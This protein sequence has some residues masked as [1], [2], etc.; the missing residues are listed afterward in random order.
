M[1][2]CGDSLGF[3]V[4]LKWP[5]E[6]LQFLTLTLF[7]L[8][9][10]RG[11]HLFQHWLCALTGTINRLAPSSSRNSIPKKMCKWVKIRSSAICR[12]SRK[13]PL[14]FLE[15]HDS[16][17]LAAGCFQI[18]SSGWTVCM[19]SSHISDDMSE[20]N[21]PRQPKEH[22]EFGKFGSEGDTIRFHQLAW[23]Q[24]RLCSYRVDNG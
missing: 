22:Q 7:G 10:D 14:V 1:E 9:M 21:V 12:Q 16:G 2:V 23:K 24:S 19:C 6:G 8:V 13:V 4:A 15:T 18:G 3:R 5:L 11:E 20:Q 17:L